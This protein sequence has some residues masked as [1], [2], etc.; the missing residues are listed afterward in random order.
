MDLVH[1]LLMQF[2]TLYSS[3]M[4]VAKIYIFHILATQNDHLSYIK[5]VLGSVHVV[6]PYLGIGCV[7]GG[8]PMDWCTT[9]P[10]FHPV[11]LK[12]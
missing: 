9:D 12:I 3:K 2:F 4:E 6:S 5:H 8:F 10:V 7:G 11:Q 1:N